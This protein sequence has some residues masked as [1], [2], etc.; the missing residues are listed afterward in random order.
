VSRAGAAERLN[1]WPAGRYSTDPAVIEARAK[2]TELFDQ[3]DACDSG[4][5][6]G[7]L[8]PSGRRL[9]LLDQLG[10]AMVELRE[11]NDATR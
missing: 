8:T 2:V 9:G 1:A 6:N 10:A 3:L 5:T 11:A 7:N 4:W